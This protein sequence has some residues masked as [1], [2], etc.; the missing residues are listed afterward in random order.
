MD[1]D[2]L[3][4]LPNIPIPSLFGVSTSLMF[5]NAR[6]LS[7]SLLLSLLSLLLLS[8]LLLF[9]SLANSEKIEFEFEIE[10]EGVGKLFDF[11]RGM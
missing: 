6:I 2:R 8:L 4:E 3:D 1:R 5:F 10:G 7:L 11:R 9:L